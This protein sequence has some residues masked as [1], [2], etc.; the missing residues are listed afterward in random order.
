MSRLYGLHPLIA[1]AITSSNEL[2]DFVVWA[3]SGDGTWADLFDMKERIH[4]NVWL[5][6]KQDCVMAEVVATVQGFGGVIKGNSLCIPN[7]HLHT[8]IMQVLTIL[9]FL[10]RNDNINDHTHKVHLRWMREERERRNKEIEKI[11]ESLVWE[12]SLLP[13]EEVVEYVRDIFAGIH[14]SLENKS[15]AEIFTE[16]DS[17]LK[18]AARK[19]RKNREEG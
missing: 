5:D 17:L 13:D 14:L 15:S 4:V 11:H 16:S 19:I 2:N 12:A 18:R 6:T 3:R 7:C 9:E 10:P 1:E 8:E